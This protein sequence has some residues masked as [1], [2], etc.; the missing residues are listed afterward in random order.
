MERKSSEHVLRDL[1]S[2]PGVVGIGV[3]EEFSSPKR[4]Y[5]R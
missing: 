5:F 1:G 3:R 4:R 2:W